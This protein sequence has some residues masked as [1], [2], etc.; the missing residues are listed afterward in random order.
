MPE[1]HLPYPLDMN[2]V[3]IILWVGGQPKG[4]IVCNRSEGEQ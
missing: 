2:I 3:I 1:L 4:I